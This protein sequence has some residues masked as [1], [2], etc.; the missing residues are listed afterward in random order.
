MVY[1]LSFV[2]DLLVTGSGDTMADAERA[3]AHNLQQL[4]ERCKAKHI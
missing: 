4:K 3:H 2:S 1:L